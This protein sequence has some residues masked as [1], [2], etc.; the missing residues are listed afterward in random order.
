MA[1][2]SKLFNLRD[3]S[4]ENRL[5]EASSKIL[6][7]SIADL[8]ALHW[9]DGNEVMRQLEETAVKRGVWDASSR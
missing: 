2:G 9:R 6:K 1:I 4:L 8:N 5:L 7:K 3:E